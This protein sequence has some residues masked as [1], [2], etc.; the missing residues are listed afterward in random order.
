MPGF[1]RQTQECL[2][3]LVST[4]RR[5]IKAENYNEILEVGGLTLLRLCAILRL[6]VLLH[7]SRSR[8]TPP[9]LRLKS[10]GLSFELQFPRGWL[11]AHP[12]SREDFTGEADVFSAIGF[13]LIISG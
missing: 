12:L 7:H 9:D 13:K 5:K 3:L 4:H 11:D 1:S 8:E 10:D 6:S 2:S